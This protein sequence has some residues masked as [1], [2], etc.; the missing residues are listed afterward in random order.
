MYAL[1]GSILIF[2]GGGGAVLVFS[3][4]P[5]LMEETSLAGCGVNTTRFS[6]SL[7]QLTCTG[8]ASFFLYI[9]GKEKHCFIFSSQLLM[10]MNDWT[11][12]IAK[13][14]LVKNLYTCTKPTIIYCSSQPFIQRKILHLHSRNHCRFTLLI[15]CLLWS[16]S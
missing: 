2:L 8:P 15:C 1:W 3:L 7:N 11:M 4:C 14:K 5:F 9:A 6:L 12:G 13:Y 10:G 16:S